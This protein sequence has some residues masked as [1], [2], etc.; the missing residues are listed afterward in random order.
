MMKEKVNRREFVKAG[1]AAVAAAGITGCATAGAGAGK[2][3]ILGGAPVVA[4]PE[5]AGLSG[6]VWITGGPLSRVAA[7][8]AAILAAHALPAR[9]SSGS[10]TGRT[11]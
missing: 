1:A 11:G 9:Y 2:L 3:A 6:G 10:R 5:A 4:K 7:W 8:G